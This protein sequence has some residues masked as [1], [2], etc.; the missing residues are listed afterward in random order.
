MKILGL[1]N[2]KWVKVSHTSNF[3]FSGKSLL[4]ID[5]CLINISEEN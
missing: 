2:D 5:L 1:I 3:M 4:Q